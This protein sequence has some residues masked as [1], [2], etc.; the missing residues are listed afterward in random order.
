M[1][2]SITRK[3]ANRNIFIWRM[4]K[5]YIKDISYQIQGACYKIWK[6]FGNAFKESIIQNALTQ[7]LAKYQ[8]VLEVQKRVEVFYEGKKVGVYVPDIVVNQIIL[9][10]LKRKPYL[11][12]QD[13]QQFWYYLKATPY[14]VGYLINFSDNGLEIKRRIY[15][16]ARPNKKD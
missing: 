4:I 16:K 7:E 9:I 13:E 12:K 11:T 3:N 14:K 6:E 5:Y 2:E 8:L 15:D 10:E 1:R